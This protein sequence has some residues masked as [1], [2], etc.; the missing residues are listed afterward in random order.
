MPSSFLPAISQSHQTDLPSSGIMSYH[1]NDREK[2]VLSGKM[3]D[4]EKIE[5]VTTFF[6]ALFEQRKLDGTIERQEAER[7]C[8]R[9]LQ[10]ASEKLCGHICDVADGRRSQRARREL[11]LCNDQ[12]RYVD[13]QGDRSSHRCILDNCDHDDRRPS[14][15]ALKRYRGDLPVRNGY[16]PRDNQ[17][18]EQ[19]SSAGREKDGKGKFTPCKMHSS[20]GRPAKHGWA[21]CWENPANQKKPVAKRPKAY[22]AHNERRPASNAASLS[23]HCTAL[24]SNRSSNGYDDSRLDY[25]DDEYNFVVAISAV[26]RKQAKREVPPKKKLTIAMSESDYDTNDDAASA[27]LGKLAASYAAALLVKKKRRRSKD[28]KGAQRNPLDLSDSK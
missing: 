5:S 4:D 14:Y 1:K 7:I 27:K 13:E 15:G 18:R 12:R 22:Y 6:Q 19:K 3:L 25:S 11:A 10:E 17:P 8:K 26:P 16:R 24:A 2:F 21:E 9:L 28:P 23:N 20:P